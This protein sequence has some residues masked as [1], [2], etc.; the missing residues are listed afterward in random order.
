MT[1][2]IDPQLQGN[3]MCQGIWGLLRHKR[4][5]W[6]LAKQDLTTALVVSFLFIPQSLAY[7][8]LAGLPLQTGL[9]ASILPAL[10]YALV[11]TS[12]V[13]A[14]G[15]VALTSMLTFSALSPL[16]EPGS[17]AY[18][19]L[20]IL[21]AFLSGVCLILMSWL[22]MG[23]LANFLSHPV[24]SG[25]ISAASILIL[26]SQLEGITGITVTGS[27]LL[28]QLDSF[29]HNKHE[30]HLTTFIVGASCV[31]FLLI[32]RK[33]L[34]RKM[35]AKVMPLVLL[36]VTGLLAV[37]L[38]L[39]SL[40]VP[41]IGALP[42]GWPNLEL[43]QFSWNSLLGLLPIALIISVIG[44]AESVALA[45]NFAAKRRQQVNS[46]RE[47]LGLGLANLAAACSA[48]FPVTG[49]ISRSVLNNDA[50]SVTPMS[51]LFAAFGLLLV[52]IYLLDWL[53]FVPQ[54]MLA[55][56]ILVAVISLIE[57]RQL[58]HLWHYS[59]EDALG[60]LS[61]LLGVLTLGLEVGLLIGVLVSLAAWLAKNSRPHIALVG[62]LPG[63]EHYRNQ[64]RYAVEVHPLILSVRIDESLMFAN[65]QEVEQRLLL[66]VSQRPE[67]RHVILM[68][69]GINYLDA[70]GLEVLLQ[71]N[72]LL[73]EQDIYL[74]LSEIKGPVLD[75]LERTS[76]LQQLTGQH[77]L[78]Q[79][80]AMQTLTR[81]ES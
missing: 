62:R 64:D 57:T 69:S 30:F 5:S 42:F 32:S 35:L 52:T 11:G 40:G 3:A 10:A 61:T 21:L 60:W 16:A 20:A 25:F 39:E 65:A 18:L 46:N 7:A 75:K 43:G 26:L 72:T 74:H 50:G 73:K 70:S 77:F 81:V 48:S 4:Y 19:T 38:G 34:G 31:A 68:G 22:R 66:E 44:F 58:P 55:A 27:T 78:T 47:L 49:G 54:A 36:L 17:D 63:T 6:N 56:V 23:F 53:Y 13:L 2:K 14:V 71:L 8:L 15:P 80:Q 37:W 45:R 51:S 67:L 12:A 59:R 1:N 79:H 76:F 28:N 41:L 29:W 33:L 24:M 9:Y